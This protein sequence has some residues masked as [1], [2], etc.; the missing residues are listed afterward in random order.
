MGYLA[1]QDQDFEALTTS[2]KKTDKVLLCASYL[3]FPTGVCGPPFGSRLAR[4]ALLSMKR[5]GVAT[6][7]TFYPQMKSGYLHLRYLED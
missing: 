1:F 2:Q 4:Y 3:I 6:L 5:A 7:Y